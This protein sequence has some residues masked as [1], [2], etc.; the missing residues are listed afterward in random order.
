MVVKL[1]LGSLHRDTSATCQ[2]RL[3][4][5]RLGKSR[6]SRLGSVRGRVETVALIILLRVALLKWL[7]SQTKW[8]VKESLSL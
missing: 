5:A 6:L 8:L 2:T 1:C 7:K 3:D 4:S